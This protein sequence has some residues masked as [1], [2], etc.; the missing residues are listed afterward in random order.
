LTKSWFEFVWIVQ[1]KFALNNMLSFALCYKKEFVWAL[2]VFEN[3]YALT[4]HSESFRN[5]DIEKD[6]SMM[7]FHNFDLLAEKVIDS[8]E[9]IIEK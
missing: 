1:K 2:N 7:E 5:F 8:R 6:A 3:D 4:L 9:W